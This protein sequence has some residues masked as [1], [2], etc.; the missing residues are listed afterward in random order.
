M[1]RHG[2]A[3]HREFKL[4]ENTG[5]HAKFSFFFDD[6][7]LAVY[8]YCFEFQILYDLFDEELRISY[9][10]INMDDRTIYFS[11]GGH[12]AFNVPFYPG[13]NQ[14]DYYL[15]FEHAET[16]DAHSLLMVI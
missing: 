9:K 14:N 13:E 5:T 12:P 11:V 2:F 8:P 4:I 6:E 10:V 7:T 3:R 16:L 1:K 15:E